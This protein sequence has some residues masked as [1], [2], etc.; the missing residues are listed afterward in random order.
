MVWGQITVSSTNPTSGTYTACNNSNVTCSSTPYY[1]ATI[2]MR[3]LSIN[4]NQVQFSIASCSGNNFSTSGTAYI[5]RDTYCN[6]TLLNSGSYT[7]G[8][9]QK[10]LTYTFNT[11]GT[12]QIYGVTQTSGGAYYYTNP[13]SVTVTA[14]VPSTPTLS[15]PSNNS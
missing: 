12:F 15:S 11:T 13:I 1:G 10:T 7:T 3:V 8:S 14:P 6:G 5:Y 9:S 2:R 4:G